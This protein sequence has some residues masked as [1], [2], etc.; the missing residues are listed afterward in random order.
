[1][2]LQLETLTEAELDARRNPASM[3]GGSS[4]DDDPETDD[5]EAMLDGSDDAAMDDGDDAASDEMTAEDEP[6]A[7]L[8]S[9][10]RTSTRGIERAS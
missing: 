6:A 9:I 4:V 5:G 3:F 10:L 7:P 8:G 2:R 1:M